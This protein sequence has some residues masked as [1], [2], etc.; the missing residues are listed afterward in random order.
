MGSDLIPVCKWGPWTAINGK[1]GTGLQAP[2]DYLGV[3][4]LLGFHANM[5]I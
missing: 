5:L 4:I 2:N 1:K 3:A